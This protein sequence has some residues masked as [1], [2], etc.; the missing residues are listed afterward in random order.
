MIHTQT[1]KS[2]LSDLDS[3]RSAREGAI[4][5]R[6]LLDFKG[7]Q[8]KLSI[9][10]GGVSFE[11]SGMDNYYRSTVKRGYEMI[12]LGAIKVMNSR[13]DAINT[14]IEKVES[15]IKLEASL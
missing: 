12:H 7:H 11:A 5:A 13:I 4:E 14:E 8:E 9:S 1:I 15:K 10:I 3:L 2:L 6:R